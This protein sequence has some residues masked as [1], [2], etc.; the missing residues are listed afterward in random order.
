MGLLSFIIY[1]QLRPAVVLRGFRPRAPG[2]LPS[3]AA[4]APRV[5]KCRA[6]L[7][8]Q[9]VQTNTIWTF[10]WRSMRNF[11]W[12]FWDDLFGWLDTHDSNMSQNGCGKE[13][14][15]TLCRRVIRREI[16]HDIPWY[17]VILFEFGTI[18]GVAGWDEN[19][20]DAPEHQD[21]PEHQDSKDGFPGCQ[22][23]ESRCIA[24]SFTSG[25][26]LVASHER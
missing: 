22:I 19:G 7:R 24:C 6:D 12:S 21:V 13:D 25:G 1:L 10:P 2:T 15:H 5:S 17:T 9:P 20:Q 18:P 8:A 16:N 11:G 14:A 4:R 3:S 26:V 23:R